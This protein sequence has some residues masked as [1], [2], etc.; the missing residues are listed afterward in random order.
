MPNPSERERRR[1]ID[2]VLFGEDK[3]SR[4]SFRDSARPT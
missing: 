3:V 1:E 2:D 4:S